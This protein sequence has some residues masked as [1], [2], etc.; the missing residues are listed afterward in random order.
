[1]EKVSIIVLVKNNENNLI[2]CVESIVFQSHK[3][4]EV[5]LAYMESTDN[6]YEICCE[7]SKKYKNVA[8]VETG[9][10]GLK[11][12]LDKINGENVIVLRPT[13]RFGHSLILTMVHAKMIYEASAAA[14]AV[15]KMESINIS[16]K[17]VHISN[18]NGFAGLPNKNVMVMFDKSKLINSNLELTTIEKSI[19]TL[20]QNDKISYVTI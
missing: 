19:S 13:K 6:S 7:L 8:M 1:M 15:D 3:L 2:N 12:V 9:D 11:A 10:E 16:M 5:C 17:K 4:C 20:V 14:V 18:C